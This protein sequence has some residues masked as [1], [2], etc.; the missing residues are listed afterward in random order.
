MGSYLLDGGRWP[1]LSQNYLGILNQPCPISG[2]IGSLTITGLLLF[3][4][5]SPTVEP[6]G[7]RGIEG[8]IWSAQ[9]QVENNS[10]CGIITQV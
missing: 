5:H 2:A 8:D 4:C 3:A 10:I 6:E 9:A 1:D 7:R